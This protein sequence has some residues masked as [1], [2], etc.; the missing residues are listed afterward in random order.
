VAAVAAAFFPAL[1]NG[2]V[3][4]DDDLNLTD[5][6]YWRG[7]GPVQLRWMFT[8]LHGGHYQPLSWISYALDYQVWGLEPTGYHLTNLVLH[9]ANAVVFWLVAME[10]L[11]SAEPA[12]KGES[13]STV[14]L[15]AAVGALFFAIHPLRVES[16][17]WASERR[18]VLSGLF[19]LLTLLSYLRA[20]RDPARRRV[21]LVVATLCFA[22]SLLSKAWAITVPAVLL[23]LDAYP[24]RRFGAG[25]PIW[26]VLTEKIAFVVL[27]GGA[28][29]LALLAQQ[30][31]AMRP[32]AQ[33]GIAARIAQAAYGLCF[34]VWRTIVPVGLSPLY[35]LEMPLDPTEPRYVLALV[36]VAATVAALVVVRRR[37][38][39]L[40]AAVACYVLIVSPVLGFVQSGQQ[41]VADRYTY[42][43]CL[44]FA[45]LVAAG[46]RRAARVWPSWARQLGGATAGIVLVTLG[47]LTL[48]Q[49]LRW[50]D[51]VTLW[52]Y[53]LTLD[54][55]SYIA[56]TNRGVARQLAGDVAGAIADYDA[57]LA[58]NPAHAEAYKNRGTARAARGQLD[59][60]V[61]DYDRAIRLKPGYADAYVSRGAA[62]EQR[63]D[64]TG[65][66]G[67]YAEACT[68]DPGH[69]RALYGR[70]NMRATRGD[71]AGSIA[72]Y[73]AALRINPGYV[74]ALNN[75]G[76]A[77]RRAGDEAGARADFMRALAVAP[78]GWPGREVIQRNLGQ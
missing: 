10:L 68:L 71:I 32:L 54:P 44:P 55:A 74:E 12:A 72:D 4:W 40:V 6:P 39:W 33:H 56:W 49:T 23:V 60:A 50:R 47:G 24:L 11:Q 19:F 61:A 30:V 29:A 46:V 26:P 28:A 21:Q 37:A 3:N 51:S 73:T 20:A 18:D 7:L 16:V 1:S 9:A 43:A 69:A 41:K 15:A 52:T 5:N 8:V 36:L 14:P 13:P 62:R 22:L 31:E 27:A 76:L 42:L 67:D 17:A 58:A 63:G 48:V 65:A 45:V 75:R 78:P 2:F 53:A 70:A 57:A 64:L 38:P 34:Y 66:L 59:E 77:K 35:L 25:R